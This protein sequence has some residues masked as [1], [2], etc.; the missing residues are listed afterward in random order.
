MITIETCTEPTGPEAHGLG[1]LRSALA[2]AGIKVADVHEATAIEAP[3]VHLMVGRTSHPAIQAA[4]AGSGLRLPSEPEATFFQPLPERAAATLLAGGADAAGVMYAL[5]ELADRIRC[6][7]LAALSK[8]DPFLEKA[9]LRIRGVDRFLSGHLDEDWFH[10]ED[11]WAYF[12]DRLA[13][14]RLNRFVLVTGFDTAWMSPPYPFFLDIPGFEAVTVEGLAPGRKAANLAR[15]RRIGRD[16]ADRAITFFF[17]IWQQ[18]PWQQGQSQLV[19][20]LPPDEDALAEFCAAGL[21][22]LLVQCP[23]I[24]GIHLRV[25]H[26]AGVGTQTTPEGFWNTLTDAVADCGRPAKLD[27]R[28]KGLSDGMIRHALDRGLDLGVPTKYWCE[29]TGLPHHLTQMRSEEL[30]RLENLN[31]ARRYSYAD[32]LRRPRRHQI[33]YRLWNLGG[34]NLFWWG[35]SEY[36]RRFCASLAVGEAPGFEFSCPLSLKGGH[37]V[38]H[39]EPWPVRIDPAEVSHTCEDERYWIQYLLFGRIGYDPAVADSVFLRDFEQRFGPEAGGQLSG[40]GAAASLVLPLVTAAHMPVH[41][42]ACYW[43]ELST[44][45]ALFATNQ[46]NPHFRE[47]TYGAAEPSDS[48]LFYGIDAYATDLLENAVADKFTPLQVARWLRSL[49]ADTRS[50]L[51]AAARASDRRPGPEWKAARTDLSMLADLADYHAEKIHAAVHL[52]LFGT[53]SA[54]S[55][56]RAALV[57]LKRARSHWQA[58]AERGTHAFRDP[59]EFRAGTAVGRTGHWRHLTTEIDRDLDCLTTLKPGS[60]AAAHSLPEA[61]TAGSTTPAF[62]DGRLPGELEVAER[63]VAGRSIRVVYRPPISPDP[64]MVFRLRYRRTNQLEGAFLSLPLLREAD[65]FAASIPAHYVTPE[66]DQLVYVTGRCDRWET[67]MLPGLFHPEA[68]LPYRLIRI[69]EA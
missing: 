3:H 21:R 47:V 2:A 60:Q 62:Q 36:V 31:H 1:R 56:R 65:G 8:P 45:G 46:A 44:G 64:A 24:A 50:A 22:E 48:G 55:H 59:L 40:A 12:L 69:T 23:E 18:T 4:A 67:R 49:A 42:M 66:F 33:I 34:T 10:S 43:P 7:G 5:L 20:G 54:E 29:Q 68:P 17:G 52:A 30:A 58:L 14:A 28:A 15:L 11:F 57:H 53:G 19:A 35:N 27:L 41:P 39:R 25:N 13:A 61:A 63:A 26:E 32:L 51:E 16:C 9:S 37:E 6:R 38:H